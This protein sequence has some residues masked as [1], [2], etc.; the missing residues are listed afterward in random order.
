MRSELECLTSTVSSVY[1]PEAFVCHVASETQ[2]QRHR[3]PRC[4]C[5]RG[6][7][8]S[9]PRASACRRVASVAALSASR[10]VCYV[11]QIRILYKYPLLLLEVFTFTFHSLQ[12]DS[13]PSITLY[14]K[15]FHQRPWPTYARSRPCSSR[16]FPSHE[17]P[18]PRVAICG[19]RTKVRQG[20]AIWSPLSHRPYGMRNH[21]E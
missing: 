8:L 16:L 3:Q 2:R 21:C 5:Q 17:Q 7:S 14:T 1:L 9:P 11:A 13:V 18:P 20:H 19:Q 6:V 4:I 15:A 10:C 12:Q